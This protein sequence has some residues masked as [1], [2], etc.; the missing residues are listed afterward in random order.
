MKRKTDDEE[1]KAVMRWFATDVTYDGEPYI[2]DA[3]QA[4]AIA[5]EHINTI[6]VARAG[7]GK[8]RTLVAKIIYLVAKM[9]VKPE[10]ILTFVFNSNAAVEI[11]ERL[12]KMLVRGAPVIPDDARIASTFHAFSRRIVYDVC[13]GKRKLGEILADK[14][15]EYILYMV[16]KMMREAK[17]ADKI[18]LFAGD[19][20]EKFASM[21]TQFVN[22]AQQKYLG[23][24]TNLG[25][26]AKKYLA[27][28][29]IP[30]REQ[31]F[32]ELGVECFRRYHWHLLRE[33]GTDFNLIV[34]WASK[35]ICGDRFEIRQLLSGKKYILIDEYQDFSQLFLAAVQAIRGVAL[36]AKLFVVGDDW[37]AINRFAGSD[38]DYFKNFEYYFPD[39][40]ARLEISTNYRCDYEIVDMARTFMKKSMGEKGHFK[41]FSGKPGKIVIVN[42][43]DIDFG[44]A[45]V[46]YDLRVSNE[47]KIYK[48]ITRRVV[49]KTPKK[50]AV[51]YIKTIMQIIKE[52]MDAE[53]ILIL[54]RNNE[55]NIMT[56]SLEQLADGIKWGLKRLGVMSLEDFDSKVTFM[57]M[58]KSKG[59]ESEVVIILEADDGVI[60]KE[61]PDTSLYKMF[62]ETDRVALDDQKRLF[63]VAI[64]RAK[65]RLYIIHEYM[66]K[67]SL[68]GFIPSLGTGVE[69]W[70]E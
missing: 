56:A 12:S 50:K 3:E 19:E 35:L 10:E 68:E 29:S 27:S 67:R 61:H 52:S 9:G 64:T 6:V 33:H 46:D 54:H 48:E 58:H 17:W 25:E 1:S 60:P 24:E 22:R 18:T 20:I 36:S 65:N 39:D 49:G 31:L 26:C 2:I 47:D 32:I 42:P 21:M 14:K 4:R 57:T 55:L 28:E 40:V 63:Y 30:L 41:A 7:S 37:Q 70:G 34:S 15:D 11:N 16:K 66:G 45:V 51:L 59:L 44:Y 23:S 13:G 69:K 8:T 62:G 38:V 53:S 43:R 5:S